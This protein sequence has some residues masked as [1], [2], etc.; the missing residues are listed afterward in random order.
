MNLLS[1]LYFLL[2]RPLELIYELIFSL[3]YKFTGSAVLSIVFLSITVGLLC[4]PLYTRA[5]ALQAEAN[6]IEKKLKPW[7]T[8]IKKN[9]KGDEQVMML[10]AYYRENNYHPLMMMRSSIS[11][12][13]QI[14]FFIS[15]Y[16]MLSSSVAL[17]GTSFGPIAD[18]GAPDGIIKI[19]AFAINLLPILMTAINIISGTIYSK[20]LDKKAKIQLY[21]TALVFLVLL[22]NSPSGLVLYWTLNNVFSLVKNIV[23]KLV[24]ASKKPKAEKEYKKDKL[25]T[26][27]FVLYALCISTLIGLLIPSDYLVR[28]VENYMW[29]YRFE[30]M[31]NYLWVSFLIGLGFF[32]VWG[33]IYF[34]VSKN[35]RLAAGVMITMASWALINYFAFY[36]NETLINNYL[37]DLYDHSFFGAPLNLVVLVLAALLIYIVFKNTRKVFLFLYIP[38][39]LA[40]IVVSISNITNIV[41]ANNSYAFVENQREYPQITLSADK[42]NV[43][44]IMLDRAGG[45]VL[46]YILNERPDLIEGFDGFTWYRNSLSFG[47]S[48]NMAIPALYGGYEYIPAEMNARSDLLLE[49]KHNEALSIMPIIFDQNGYNVTMLDPSYAGYKLVPDLSIYEDYPD[50]NAYISYEILNPYFDELADNRSDYFER[51]FFVFGFRLASPIAIREL[52]YDYGYY[53]DLNSRLLNNTFFQSISDNSHATGYNLTYMNSYYTL[54]SLPA[55]TEFSDGAETGSFVF[56]DNTASHEPTLL[57]EPEYAISNTVDNAVYDQEHTDRL[58]L[59]GVSLELYYPEEMGYYHVQVQAYET[60]VQWFDYLREQ[61]V[62][63][64]TRIIIVSDHGAR[65]WLFGNTCDNAGNSLGINGFN[66]LVMVKDFGAT[67]F[68]VSDEFMTNA[69]TPSFAFNG[70]IEDPVNPFTGNPVVSRLD[71]PEDFLYFISGNNNVYDNNGNTFTAGDWYTYNPS[72]GDIFDE[73]AWEYEGN[74]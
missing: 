39:A 14:P 6:A 63:D 38:I 57:E 56:I 55:I 21:V 40:I 26:A 33:G 53:N 13:L 34:Y 69:E 60:L 70:L 50:I 64:N 27:L 17:Q 1:I 68:N 58:T 46:P 54:L 73:S 11:L 51:N 16:H 22:Y 19:G 15:A 5:D 59:D 74:Y 18:L 45:R 25:D 32:L 3:S 35:K 44:V 71:Y 65:Y 49:D 23:M 4:L 10:Q 37:N 12:L 20:D 24:P 43:V 7:K 2:I 48:T 31:S 41:K 8:E 47:Q 52:L 28:A 36:C 72:S 66:C 61:G 9:F 67:G 29:N 62:Y 30:N 42:P